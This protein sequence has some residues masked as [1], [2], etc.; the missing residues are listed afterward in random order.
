MRLTN[1][2]GNKVE[3]HAYSVALCAL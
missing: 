2:F 3:N 1:R